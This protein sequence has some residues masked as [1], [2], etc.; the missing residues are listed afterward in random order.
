MKVG[1]EN[2]EE[3][4]SMLD[5]R[6]FCGKYMDEILGRGNRDSVIMSLNALVLLQRTLDAAGV[7]PIGHE[8]K[9]SENGRPYFDG[10]KALDFSISHS[11]SAVACALSADGEGNVG[12]DVERVDGQR[13]TERF[14][15]RFFS[16]NERAALEAAEDTERSWTRIWT[17]KEAYIKYL[18][19]SP[20][21]LSE[22][23]TED[24]D[25]VRFDSTFFTLDGGAEYCLTL[26]RGVGTDRKTVKIKELV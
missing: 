25:E 10:L 18:G 9:R 5:K 21:R 19:G 4:L 8:L 17:K 12:V 26:C 20:V 22:L 24:A 3:L 11:E 14:A 15:K 2:A 23:D 6:I 7:C 16:E 1:K 13:D